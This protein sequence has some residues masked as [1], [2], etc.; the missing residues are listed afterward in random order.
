MIDQS[1]SKNPLHLPWKGWVAYLSLSLWHLTYRPLH[2]SRTDNAGVIYHWSAERKLIPERG[3]HLCIIQNFYLIC[4]FRIGVGVLSSFPKA[5]YKCVF[6]PLSLTLLMS[7]IQ[8]SQEETPEKPWII[9]HSKFKYIIPKLKP[10]II[11][12]LH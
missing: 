11:V 7:M 5:Y 8:R 4:H 12:L 10:D 1:G 3:L 6:F 9:F 2:F